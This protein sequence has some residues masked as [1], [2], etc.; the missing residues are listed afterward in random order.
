MSTGV[1][2]IRLTSLAVFKLEKDNEYGMELL[3]LLSNFLSTYLFKIL[4]V[5]YYFISLSFII[6]SPFSLLF[7][8]LFLYFTCLCS[9]P[10]NLMVT[11][12]YMCR[13]SNRSLLHF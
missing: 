3:L 10:Y 8:L 12:V 11:T 7:Y 13:S 2:F 4:N 9:Y 5:L 6:L 1:N